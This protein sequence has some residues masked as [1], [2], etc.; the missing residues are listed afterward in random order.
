MRL[1]SIGLILLLVAAIGAIGQ[2][3]PMTSS[4][5]SYWDT[6]KSVAIHGDYAYVSAS[7]G[8]L[9]TYRISDLSNPVL[10]S[11]VRVGGATNLTIIDGILW[12]IGAGYAALSLENP[13]DPELL[14]FSFPHATWDSRAATDGKLLAFGWDASF[15]TR[16]GDVRQQYFRILDVTDV[17]NPRQFYEQENRFYQPGSVLKDSVLWGGIHLTAVSLMD[18]VNPEI[19]TN[20]DLDCYPWGCNR[21]GHLLY[22]S[23]WVDQQSQFCTV[24]ITDLLHPSLVAHYTDYRNVCV[25]VIDDTLISFIYGTNRFA[26]LNLAD[27]ALPDV[28]TDEPTQAGS[29]ALGVGEQAVAVVDSLGQVGL[30]HRR[31]LQEFDHTFNIVNSGN[32]QAVAVVGDKAFVAERDRGLLIVE[33]GDINNPQELGSLRLPVSITK[34]AATREDRIFAVTADSGIFVCSA[35][36]PAHPAILGRRTSGNDIEKILA[37]GDYFYYIESGNQ[38]RVI[39]ATDPENP[40]RATLGTFNGFGKFANELVASDGANA[41]VFDVSDPRHPA[42]TRIIRLPRSDVEHYSI[43]DVYPAGEVLY[44]ISYTWWFIEPGMSY[45]GFSIGKVRIDD[46]DS[47]IYLGGMELVGGEGPSVVGKMLARKDNCFVFATS[48]QAFLIREESNHFNN[49]YLF[50]GVSRVSD[51]EIAGTTVYLAAGFELAIYNCADYLA[52]P[53]DQIKPIPNSFSLSAYPNP[54]N[55]QVTLNYTLHKMG[56]VEIEVFD[57]LGRQVATIPQGYQLPGEHKLNWNAKVLPSGQYQVV[58]KQRDEKVV[59]QVTLTR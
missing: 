32:V 29:L 37:D 26:C 38:L 4:I 45:A 28:L 40:Q 18:P 43:I 9:Y 6:P 8:N 30:Y 24:D 53:Q 11:V 55:G 52:A 20:S 34:I 41:V 50:E 31:D 35:A 36:D 44:Y 19:L 14:F 47:A 33:A 13:A 51:A 27:P 25:P 12:E 22:C 5:Y 57:A 54:F 59:H 7:N 16:F 23:E 58:L 46:N 3:I 48:R 49:L 56:L 1:F 15:W 39:D 17:Q 10:S 42:Q 2:S 21:S